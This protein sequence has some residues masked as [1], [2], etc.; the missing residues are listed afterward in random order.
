MTGT[1]TKTSEDMKASPKAA[2]QATDHPAAVRAAADALAA[3]VAAARAAGYQ[4]DFRDAA[5]TRIAVSETKRV[6]R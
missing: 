6:K 4:V 2:E 3:A 1:E 5:L